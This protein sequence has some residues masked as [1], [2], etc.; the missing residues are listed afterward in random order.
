ME[1]KPSGLR[2]LRK[3]L[4]ALLIVAAVL[5]GAQFLRQKA[6]IEF[7]ANSIH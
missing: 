3:P 4:I 6:G 1:A 7:S 2:A 5:V